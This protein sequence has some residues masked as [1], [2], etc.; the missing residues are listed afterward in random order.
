[1]LP[2]L[3]G[4]CG[5]IAVFLMAARTKVPMHWIFTE[6]RYTFLRLLGF[7]LLEFGVL[8]F[9]IRKCPEVRERSYW[10]FIAT[11]LGLAVW[12]LVSLGASSDLTM[13]ASIPGLFCFWV[14]VARALFSAN[15]PR[16]ERRLLEWLVLAGSVTAIS[17]MARGLQ[18]PQPE[19]YVVNEYTSVMQMPHED[20]LQYVG[21]PR[22]AVSGWLFK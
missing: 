14:F 22:H 7:Y 9:I 17:E 18:L 3:A 20:T 21:K 11:L 8:A 4:W 16:L 5:I 6:E 13:R 2:L 15:M 19:R 12:P 10:L 1:M